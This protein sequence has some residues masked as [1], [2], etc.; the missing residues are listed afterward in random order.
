MAA[1][2]TAQVLGQIGTLNIPALLA[3]LASMLVAALASPALQA[4]VEGLVA[5]ALPGPLFFLKPLLPAAVG[6]LLGGLA[7]HLGVSPDDAVAGG[8]ALAGALHWVNGQPWAADLEGKY[9]KVWNVLK[10]LGSGTGSKAAVLLV[11]LLALGAGSARAEV[12][13][14]YGGLFGSSTWTAGPGGTFKATGSTLGGAEINA[15]YGSLSGTA[16]TPDVVLALGGAWEDFNGN[17]YGDLIL[18]AGPTIPGTTAPLIVG[19]AWRMFTGDRY[20]A[21]MV[22]TTFTFGQPF[23]EGK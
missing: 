22:G 10:G 21:L 16:F 17:Q 13:L 18:G 1:S 2:Q 19:P 6:S 23:W 3:L 11:G 20:P 15:A 8:A 14:S 9:P 12:A 7:A 5:V 4:A